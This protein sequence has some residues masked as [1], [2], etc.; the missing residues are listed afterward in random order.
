MYGGQLFSEFR[1][2]YPGPLGPALSHLQHMLPLSVVAG[3]RQYDIT[4]LHNFIDVAS[5]QSFVPEGGSSSGNFEEVAVVSGL[6]QSL[7]SGGIPSS[8]ICVFAAYRTQVKLLH[9]EAIQAQWKDCFIDT[10]DKSQGQ[11]FLFVI[12]SLVK[13]EG[14]AGFIEEL[15]RACVGCSRHK[16]AL[17]LVGN[18]KFWASKKAHGYSTMSRLIDQMKLTSGPNRDMPELVVRGKNM[19][20]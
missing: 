10:I 9:Q 2:D 11:E 5:G 18:W 15:G 6:V 1:R 19:G 16:I 4:T 13:T 7:K 8:Q 12:I 14:D 17:Y 3:N 20:S